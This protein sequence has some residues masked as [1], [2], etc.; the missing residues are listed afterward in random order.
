MSDA[1]RWGRAGEM[2][3]DPWSWQGFC[4][5]MRCSTVRLDGDCAAL[6][7]MENAQLCI[8]NGRTLWRM[9]ISQ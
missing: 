9:S 8:L 2:G 5:V 7:L 1:A 4:W 3:N 6:I